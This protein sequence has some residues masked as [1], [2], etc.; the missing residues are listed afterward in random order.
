MKFEVGQK[1]WYVQ[2]EY[3]RRQVDPGHEVT[4]TKIG[5][6]WIHILGP[7]IHAKD[8]FDLEYMQIDGGE[9]TSP[10]RVHLSEQ[11]YKDHLYSLR[12]WSSFVGKLPFQPYHPYEVTLKAAAVLDITL[13]T[14][15]RPVET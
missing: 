9:Y 3:L 10:G 15:R 4:V 5:R 2:S 8:K 1:L 13:D 14:V 7:H 11:H 12:L 6:K